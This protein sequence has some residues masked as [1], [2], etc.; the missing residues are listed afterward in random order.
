MRGWILWAVVAGA[1]G[2]CVRTNADFGDAEASATDTASASTSTSTPATAGDATGA[3][4]QA[5]SSASSDDTAV[6]DET[7]EPTAETGM[8]ETGG[9]PPPVCEDDQWFI[10]FPAF[11]DACAAAPG[12]EVNPGECV[13]VGPGADGQIVVTS[14]FGCDNADAQCISPDGAP[15]VS[16]V[17]PQLE[18][19]ELFGDDPSSRCGELWLYGYASGGGP[20]Y[21]D[22]MMF[23]T[24]PGELLFGLSN[25]PGEALPPVSSPAGTVLNET[26]VVGLSRCGDDVVCPEPGA[27]G[28]RFGA[29]PQLALPGGAPVETSVPVL[30][31]DGQIDTQAVSVFNFGLDRGL[32][33][34]VRGRWAV[35][36]EDA[37]FLF[38]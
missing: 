30:G 27:L 1:S 5:A 11:P 16:L 7:M 20:C 4:G 22:A 19:Q 10:D 26:E 21:W 24:N 2:G 23:W 32:D 37:L 35:T 33:C 18:L 13:R 38:Q 9:P 17:I 29:N 3:S 25:I 36:G 6:G 12:T 15:E 31:D 34:K 14:A 28:V 8:G